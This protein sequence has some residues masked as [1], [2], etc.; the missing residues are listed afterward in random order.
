MKLFCPYY[1]LSHSTHL[2]C[3][4]SF[5]SFR[6][7]RSILQHCLN[8]EV[9]LVSHI[10]VHVGIWLVLWK[11][12][13]WFLYCSIRFIIK[14]VLIFTFKLNCCSSDQALL[15]YLYQLYLFQLQMRKKALYLCHADRLVI[16]YISDRSSF[17]RDS[18]A[19]NANN[20]DHKKWS[21]LVVN[22]IIKLLDNSYVWLC[23]T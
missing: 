20:Y 6:F 12:Y 13:I 10:L 23:I 19:S 22:E 3:C 17:T 18:I 4:L 2:I 16:V 15:L 1:S 5:F 7:S 21:M 9:S 11:W 14:K 8:R